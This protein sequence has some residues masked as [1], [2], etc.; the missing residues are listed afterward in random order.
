M[1]VN[2]I[3]DINGIEIFPTDD[4]TEILKKTIHLKK[5]IRNDNNLQM[6]YF[7]DV[8]I[9]KK[10]TNISLVFSEV[11]KLRQILM[12]FSMYDEKSYTI[13]IFNKFFYENKISN[14]FFFEKGKGELIYEPHFK[15][16]TI[17]ISYN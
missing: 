2:G 7:E 15:E 4:L 5:S 10:F 11:G 16:Y 9:C 12:G 6:L 13:E 8:L 17:K 3:V 14:P 1:I